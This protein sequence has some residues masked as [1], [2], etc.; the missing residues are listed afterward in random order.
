MKQAAYANHFAEEKGAAAVEFAL[1]LPL[2]TL[3]VFGIIVFGMIFNSYLGITHAAKEGARWA[4]LGNSWPE[5]GAKIKSSSPAIDW[6][7]AD[8]KIT[9][10]PPGG[11]TEVDQSNPVTI[12]ITYDLPEG[13]LSLGQSI[14]LLG[15][16]F[17][18][19][20]IMPSKLSSQATLRIE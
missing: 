6:S 15:A 8:I 11:A 18:A 1:L 19:G 4:A 14:N 5:I 10:V 2:L 3:F 13:I 17:G 9:G 12:Q 20:T 7:R 16:T